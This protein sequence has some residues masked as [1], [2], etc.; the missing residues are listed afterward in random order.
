MI[1]ALGVGVCRQ[2]SRRTA[3]LQDGNMIV[4]AVSPDGG[5]ASLQADGNVVTI[6]GEIDQANPKVFL[7]PFLE[8]IHVAAEREGLREVKVSLSVETET[9]SVTIID[10]GP[11]VAE[12]IRDSLFDPFVSEGKQKGTGL[13][14][15]LAWSVAR[16]HGGDVKLISSHPGETIFRLTVTRCHPESTSKPSHSPSGALMS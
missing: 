6:R 4:N 3:R 9:V 1:E 12:G 16:E 15:T 14:L 5:R 2:P 8:E 13:G 11:G 7:A 10:N